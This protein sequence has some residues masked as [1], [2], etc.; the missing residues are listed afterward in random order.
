MTRDLTPYHAF[1]S[2]EISDC[3]TFVRLV[4]L[5]QNIHTYLELREFMRL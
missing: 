1:A 4:A 3:Q 5:F 2:F